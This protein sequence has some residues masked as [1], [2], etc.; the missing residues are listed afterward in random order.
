MSNSNEQPLVAPNGIEE[1]DA[2]S[3]PLDLSSVKADKQSGVSFSS[4]P[5]LVKEKKLKKKLSTRRLSI[6]TAENMGPDIQEHDNEEAAPD[7]E[8]SESANSSRESP[9]TPAP[10]YQD[11]GTVPL[12]NEPITRKLSI[13]QDSLGSVGKTSRP[14]SLM[15]TLASIRP[16]HPHHKEE[17]DTS[18]SDQNSSQASSS[19]G[20]FTH[21]VKKYWIGI[22]NGEA[23]RRLRTWLITA[24]FEIAIQ[25]TGV[26]IVCAFLIYGVYFIPNSDVESIKISNA[27]HITANVLGHLII[28]AIYGYSSAIKNA[29]VAVKL[30]KRGATLKEINMGAFATEIPGSRLRQFMLLLALIIDVFLL[31]TTYNFSFEEFETLYYSDVCI[32]ATYPQLT[33]PVSDLGNFL[34]GETDLALI[35]N[36]ALPTSDGLLG[37]W[38]SWPLTNPGND[39]YMYRIVLLTARTDNGTAYALYVNCFPEIPSNTSYDGSILSVTSLH[40]VQYT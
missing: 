31:M 26:F 25:F 19:G 30:N 18:D 14:T 20:S 2:Q 21:K 23:M 32:S 3:I 38:S 34:Q 5:T 15:M 10:L 33:S 37:G 12:A 11:S 22:Y 1:K 39:F 17:S 16:Q 36:Y 9:S 8:R 35:Y 13:R 6:M 7:T 27:I 28:L 24:R 40:Q 4:F 29:I